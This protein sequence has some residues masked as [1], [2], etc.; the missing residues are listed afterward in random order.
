MEAETEQKVV[1]K[2]AALWGASPCTVVH[3]YN[4]LSPPSGQN[5]HSHSTTL[6]TPPQWQHYQTAR[7]HLREPQYRPKNENDECSGSAGSKKAAGQKGR[8]RWGRWVMVC[9]G[10][11]HHGE[12]KI[13]LYRRVL[14][15]NKKMD[16]EEL[17]SL[18]P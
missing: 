17:A 4:M 3:P 11:W 12:T 1:I 2:I 5:T 6:K 7:R 14:D 16:S 10:L 15:K 18:R 9:A 8:R 13:G